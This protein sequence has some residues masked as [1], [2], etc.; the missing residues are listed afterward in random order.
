MCGRSGTA[1]LV[2]VFGCGCNA[3]AVVGQCMAH[4]DV[5]KSHV[6]VGDRLFS[7]WLYRVPL[8]EKVGCIGITAGMHTHAD[9][10]VHSTPSFASLKLT[11]HEIA[12]NPP[13]QSTPRARGVVANSRAELKEAFYHVLRSHA[14]E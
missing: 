2:A 12:L 14:D 7:A 10:A 9:V 6:L 5:V 11:N 1:A 8:K 3:V 4:R 13:G